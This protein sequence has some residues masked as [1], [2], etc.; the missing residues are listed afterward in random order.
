MGLNKLQ[1]KSR[2]KHSIRVK[3]SGTSEKPRM[4]VFR[5]N[6][7]IY[8]QLIDDINANTLVS[9][10]SRDSSISGANKTEISKSVGELIA[11]KAMDKGIENVV[12]DRNGKKYHGRV[13]ALADGARETGLK[14]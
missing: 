3:I 5:S 6:K 10:D 2:I 11:K 9:A 7:A 4:S 8:V 14:F 13:K 12:F 1:R